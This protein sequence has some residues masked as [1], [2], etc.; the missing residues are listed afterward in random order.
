MR[1]ITKAYYKLIFQERHTRCTGVLCCQSYG[2][3]Y[4]FQEVVESGVYHHSRMI[5]PTGK[6]VLKWKNVYHCLFQSYGFSAQTCITCSPSAMK[7]MEW[8]LRPLDQ[9][10]G[11]TRRG[12]EKQMLSL[13]HL[14]VEIVETTDVWQPS[15]LQCYAMAF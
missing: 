2:C 15:Q 10:L 11:K 4:D 6:P 1:R 12:R 3:L 7:T 14:P 8:T 9:L 5:L 13:I